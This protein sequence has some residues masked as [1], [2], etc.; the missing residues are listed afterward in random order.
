V[1]PMTKTKTY[2]ALAAVTLFAAVLIGSTLWSNHKLAKAE[3]DLEVAKRTAATADTRSRDLE[4][5][6]AEYKQKIEYLEESLSALGQIASK[7]DE[8]I[9]LLETDTRNARHTA[10]R[11]RAVRK[12]ESTAAELC[13]KLAELGHPCE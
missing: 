9:K 2:I 12:G 10:D 5:A 7:Q 13:R 8:D 1:T 4:Q 11:A 6:A 3:R